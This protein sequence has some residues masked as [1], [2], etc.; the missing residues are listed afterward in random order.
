M[1]TESQHPDT[2]QISQVGLI[3]YDGHSYLEIQSSQS[4]ADNAASQ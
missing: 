1:N 4:T 3:T 2:D